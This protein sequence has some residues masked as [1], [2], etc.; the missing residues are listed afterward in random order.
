MLVIFFSKGRSKQTKKLTAWTDKTL[1]L[2][3]VDD[4]KDK[5]RYFFFLVYYYFL[6]RPKDC[7]FA[8]MNTLTTTAA[9]ST[10]W[11][12]LNRLIILTLLYLLTCSAFPAPSTATASPFS[13]PLPSADITVAVNGPLAVERGGQ[14]VIHSHQLMNISTSSA[15]TSAATSTCSITFLSDAGNP[16]GTVWPETTTCNHTKGP[17][18]TY[19]HYGCHNQY[20]TL[21]F[22]IILSNNDNDSNVTAF[23]AEFSLSVHIVPSER[24]PLLELLTAVENDTTNEHSVTVHCPPQY[25]GHCWYSLPNGL[26]LQADIKGNGVTGRP[27]PCGQSPKHPFIYRSTN[28]TTPVLNNAISIETGCMTT[29][30]ISDYNRYNILIVDSATSHHSEPLRL[31]NSFLIITEFATTPLTIDSLGGSIE[32]HGL[33]RTRNLKLTFPVL[34]IGGLY[35]SYSAKQGFLDTTVFTYSDLEQGLVTFVPD[36]T[37]AAA[38][39]PTKSQYHYYVSDFAGQ[40][41]AKGILEVTVSPR[42]GLK[43]SIRRNLGFSLFANETAEINQD[44]LNFYPPSECLSYVMN[45]IK[46]PLLGDLYFSNSTRPLE[47]G[48]QLSITGG[49]LLLRYT[50]R[51]H[52]ASYDM[53]STTITC[54]KKEP[55]NVTLPVRIISPD[56]VALPTDNIV[57]NC[58]QTLYGYRGFVT[59]L[60]AATGEC[61]NQVISAN[62]SSASIISHGSLPHLV[63]VD[64]KCNNTRFHSYPYIN[65]SDYSWDECFSGITSQQLDNDQLSRLWYHVP[66]NGNHSNSSTLLISYDNG[67]SLLVIYNVI[68]LS[69]TPLNDFK[70]I[71]NSEKLNY[72]HI[73]PPQ[74]YLRRNVQ[75]PLYTSDSILITSHFLYVQSLGYLQSEIIYQIVTPPEHG[76]VCLLYHSK[77]CS[78]SIRD[79]TQEDILSDQ[80]YYKPLIAEG[81]STITNENY[82]DKFVFEVYFMDDIKLNADNQFKLQ[83][84]YLQ[85]K[86]SVVSQFW[87]KYGKTKALLRKH[88]KHLKHPSIPLSRHNFT[89]REQPALG[90]VDMTEF[91]WQDIIDRKV[92]YHHKQDHGGCSDLILLTVKA[93][94]EIFEASIIVAFRNKTKSNEVGGTKQHKLDEGESFTL[95]VN[96]LPIKTSFCPEFVRVSIKRPLYYGLLIIQDPAYH[97]KRFLSANASFLLSDVIEGH[98]SYQLQPDMVIIEDVKDELLFGVTDPRGIFEDSSIMK[99]DTTTTADIFHLLILVVPIEGSG[100]AFEFNISSTVSKQVVELENNKY[101]SVLDSSDLYLTNTDFLPSEVHFIIHELPQYGQLQKN[102]YPIE[103]FTLADINSGNISYISTLPHLT[104]DVMQDEFRYS[105]HIEIFDTNRRISLDNG[106]QFNW[107][108]FTVDSTYEFNTTEE[109]TPTTSFTVRLVNKCP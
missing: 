26:P 100:L 44:H 11:Q 32:D 65:Q 48:N 108:Y 14:S 104:P 69:T 5:L 23:I 107:C 86:E 8:T 106:F 21:H 60:T 79:F 55:F 88:L 75:L 81:D 38:Y 102:N 53:I 92:K 83:L 77:A 25:I 74:P 67:I 85:N 39:I 33:P 29:A 49:N 9:T 101:G 22:R 94:E 50:H 27:I 35:P 78:Q 46:L 97:T 64:K 93:N 31:P 76:L 40:I 59:P 45:I 54:P 109:T 28:T 72:T 24:F 34:P 36:E 90:Y 19:T 4:S 98:I 89:L 2:L 3:C 68:T 15:V 80:L 12:S 73:N 20:E 71:V 30:A 7:P 52:L 57:Y 41:L 91:T 56:H 42:L 63:F 13:S 58:S 62:V 51:R 61:V 103:D 16:C 105:I 17:R 6:P 99:R 87:V 1:Q 10:T 37:S 70:Q 96:D 43:P 82:M 66:L 84:L 18:P 47:I 95:S